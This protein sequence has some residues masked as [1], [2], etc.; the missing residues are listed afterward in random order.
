M[1]ATCLCGGVECELLPPIQA[2]GHCHCEY[3]RKAHGAAFVTWVVLRSEQVRVREGEHLLV[4]Y[5]SSNASRRAFCG[6]CG[7][8]MLFRSELCPGETH[9]ARA[10]IDGEIDAPPEAHCFPE[11][12]VKWVA[13]ADELPQLSSD[14][15]ALAK[16]RAVA[17]ARRVRPKAL[18]TICAYPAVRGA[19]RMITFLRDVFGGE[20]LLRQEHR[21]GRMKHARVKVGR[22]VIMI[23][24]ADEP[25]EEMPVAAFVAVD[26]VDA[27]HR[28]ALEHGA[29]SLLEPNDRFYGDRVGGVQDPFGN[30]WWIGTPIEEVGF[31][32]IARRWLER[33]DG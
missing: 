29:T 26:D 32:E 1:R 14:S 6:V 22:S 2:Y 17:P 19:G 25:Q 9:V 5:R 21:D 13:L 20:E 7:S 23:T 33:R 4:W 3:C 31:D 27:V 12:R 16:Y 11:Q 28:R 8:S 18:D 30:V 24:E 15:A 10:L